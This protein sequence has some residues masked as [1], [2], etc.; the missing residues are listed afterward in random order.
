MIRSGSVVITTS[1][2]PQ[3]DTGCF[4]WDT[5]TPR[6]MQHKRGLSIREHS[7]PSAQCRLGN[8]PCSLSDCGTKCLV[9]KKWRVTPK[10][11]VRFG[12]SRLFFEIFPIHGV[13]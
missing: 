8:G 5:R 11:P 7:V 12:H 1:L 6:P 3:S 2:K 13:V 10:V 4:A 9:S